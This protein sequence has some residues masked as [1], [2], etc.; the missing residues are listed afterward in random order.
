MKIG[1]VSP[2][3]IFKGG[4]VQELVLA[5][6]DALSQRGHDVKIITPQPRGYKDPAPEGVIFVGVSTDVKSPLNTTVQ[7]SSAN[8][9]RMAEML[10][11]EDFDILN[12]HE[13]W[14]PMISRQILGKSN[15]INI[16]TFHAKLPDT[17]VSKTIEKVV[18]P[19]TKSILK[20]FDSF[21]AVS[22]AAADYLQKLTDDKIDII[23]NGIDLN[24]YYP[25][26]E[27]KSKNPTIFYVG[28]LEKRKGLKYLLKAFAE[29]E[30]I[31]PNS[32]LIIAGD[33]P[34]REKLKDFADDLGIQNIRFLGFVDEST[35]IKYLQ[36]STVFCSP[37]VHGESFGI[38]LLEAMACGTVIVAGD[39][40]GYSSVMQERGKLSLVNPRYT[41]ELVRRLHLMLTDNELR[42]STISWSNEYVKRYDYSTIV[43]QYEDLFNKLYIRRSG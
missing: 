8:G 16:G 19:Y 26:P 15:A 33:G 1:L 12:F 25:K 27:S 39:N 10:E 22:I 29:L 9:E 40:P 21:T 32:E 5:L 3:N 30:S 34:D 36:S 35:K 2:Y 23:P 28:R 13:P 7:I 38:V 24:K 42:D 4:G 17:R 43:D 31:L 14:V 20:Y 37:A 11:E 18:V 41:S 6:R